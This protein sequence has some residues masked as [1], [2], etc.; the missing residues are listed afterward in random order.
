MTLNASNPLHPTTETLQ[1]YSLGKLDDDAAEAVN[2]HLEHCPDCRRQVAEMAPDTF[3]GR[4]RDV[5]AGTA[6]SALSG[7]TPGETQL[8]TGTGAEAT[9][10]PPTSD[11]SPC[12]PTPRT[13]PRWTHR[14]ARVSRPGPAS[15]TSATTSCRRV[16]GEGGMGIVY[17]ARQLS[18]NRLVAL[19]MIKAAAVRLA[20]TRSAGSRTRPRRSPGSTTRTSCRSSR[21]ASSRTSTISA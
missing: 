9:L 10:D 12:S 11:E 17:K 2:N 7:T 6:A 21:S 5:Q 19:K 3:L 1:A 4:L 16:L 14:P 18:L 8:E 13:P 20:P 15:A